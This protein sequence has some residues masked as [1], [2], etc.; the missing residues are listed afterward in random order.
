MGNGK[1]KS[2]K[3]TLSTIVPPETLDALREYC[4]EH[5]RVLS[6]V[7]NEAITDWLDNSNTRKDDRDVR[8]RLGKRA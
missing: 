6:W 2:K 4:K 7:V 3:V 8:Q 5:G 1:I